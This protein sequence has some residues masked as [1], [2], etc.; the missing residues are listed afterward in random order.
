MA[1]TLSQQGFGT[2]QEILSSPVT[3]VLDLM[4]YVRFQDDYAATVTA[5]Q[6]EDQKEKP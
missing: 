1:A 4:A 3:R 6:Q 5:Y 2:V